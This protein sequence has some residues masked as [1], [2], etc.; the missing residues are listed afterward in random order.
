MKDAMIYDHPD[1]EPASPSTPIDLIHEIIVL[2]CACFE[3]RKAY[4]H[5]EI[6]ANMKVSVSITT[7]IKVVEYEFIGGYSIEPKSWDG[8]EMF[9]C[10]Y[11]DAMYLMGIVL[12]LQAIAKVGMK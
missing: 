2:S 10:F 7:E 5:I 11:D 12:K 3:K 8:V 4:V 6:S 9:V 1:F